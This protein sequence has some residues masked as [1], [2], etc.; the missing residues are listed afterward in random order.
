[1]LRFLSASVLVTLL[2]VSA[3]GGG[4]APPAPAGQ[5]VGKPTLI[6]LWTF[7]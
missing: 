5:A 7:P 3:C 6:Y 1:V 2:L 4:N